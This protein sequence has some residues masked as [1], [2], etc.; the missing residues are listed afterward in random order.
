MNALLERLREHRLRVHPIAAD[1]NC[2][3]SV[4]LHQCNL[5]GESFA[6]EN[7]VTALRAATAD[8]MLKNSADYQPFIE[9]V[10]RDSERFGAYCERI[11]TETVWGGQVELRAVAEFLNVCI[12]V[13]AVGLPIVK[14][15]DET[16]PVLRVSYH[17]KYFGLGEHYNSLVPI[18]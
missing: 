9:S 3:Y 2:M 8:Y 12:E 4:V 6:L 7:T 14:M 17:R 13:Y 15:G 10:E 18:A 11:R 5:S 16:Q 1:R